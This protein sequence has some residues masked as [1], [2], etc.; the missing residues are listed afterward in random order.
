MK[1]NTIRTSL[2]DRMVKQEHQRVAAD[3]AADT[4]L[5]KLLIKIN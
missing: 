5:G 4:A 3:T 1:K 2:E